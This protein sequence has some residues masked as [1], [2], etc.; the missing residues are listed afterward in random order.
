MKHIINHFKKNDPVLHSAIL[1]FESLDF[2]VL[3]KSDDY[4]RSLCREIIG[5]QLAGAAADKIFGRFENLFTKKVITPEKLLQIPD[6]KIRDAGTSWA[7]VRYLKD[8]ATKVKNCEVNLK[9]LDEMKNELVQEKLGKIK[10]VGPW[11]SEMFL[12][13]SLA[14]EDIFSHGDLG[15][16]KAIMKLYKFKREPSKKQVEKIVVKWSPY[17]TYACL[18]LWKSHD[19]KL[20]I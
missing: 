12:M 17:K 19:I 4:F 20:P 15:L 3:T 16:K 18:I 2:L 7:K 14:R 8:L 1:K 13:F 10:G 11:T 5:Q 9:K 6:Q